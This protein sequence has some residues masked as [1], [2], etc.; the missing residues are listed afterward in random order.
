MPFAITKCAINDHSGGS[1]T[2]IITV[3]RIRAVR[4]I[5]GSVDCLISHVFKH[6]GACRYAVIP[7]NER[8]VLK[9]ERQ[10]VTVGSHWTVPPPQ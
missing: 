6:V 9:A 10:T 2:K 4:R 5:L 1:A 8:S 7:E 3:E